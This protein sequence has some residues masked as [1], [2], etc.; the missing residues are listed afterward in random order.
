MSQIP[1][2]THKKV[3]LAAGETDY[4]EMSV[5]RGSVSAF[6]IHWT[7]GSEASFE[8]Q[9]TCVPNTALGTELAE[10]DVYW[11]PESSVT[12]SGGGDSS[13]PTDGAETVHVSGLGTPRARLRIDCTA[14][15]TYT[16]FHHGKD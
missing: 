14:S 2:H 7:G 13:I 9:T 16:L 8:Y 11:Q 15:G 4:L 12:I 10:D 1:S 5:A 6:T 3:T